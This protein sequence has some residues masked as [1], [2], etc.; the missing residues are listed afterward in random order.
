M[1]RAHVR[2]AQ[3]RVRATPTH[4]RTHHGTVILS[5]GTLDYTFK[6]LIHLNRSRQW[7]PARSYQEARQLSPFPNTPVI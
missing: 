2:V 6:G 5:D 7:E 3:P 1:K 4:H